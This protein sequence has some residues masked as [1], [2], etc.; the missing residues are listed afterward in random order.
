MK[1]KIEKILKIIFAVGAFSFTPLLLTYGDP[2]FADYNL[3]GQ[4]AAGF[5]IIAM[6]FIAVLIVSAVLTG[7]RWVWDKVWD[8]IKK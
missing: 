4:W 7:I 6:V 2:I 1:E 5:I 8:R 3:L